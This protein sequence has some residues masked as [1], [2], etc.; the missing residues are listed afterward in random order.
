VSPKSAD[1][2][3]RAEL[4]EVAARLVAT[5]GQSGLTLR[6]LAKEVGTSTMAVYTH[7]G[8]MDQLRRE[9]RREGFSRLRARLDQV[10]KT[11]DPVADL[12][13]LGAAYYSS[14]TASPHLYRAMFLEGPVDGSDF[15]TG[16]DTFLRLVDA[17]RRCI[18]SGRLPDAAPSNPEELAV[19]MWALTHGLCSLQLAGLLEEDEALPRLSTAARS[20][21]LSWGDDPAAYERSAETARCRLETL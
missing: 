19:E 1:P 10:E 13:M 9:V 17:L 11:R 5:G 7:F 3:L 2:A 6:R 18:E 8:G 4:V 14:A 20:L 12:I 21:M 16:L 15:A